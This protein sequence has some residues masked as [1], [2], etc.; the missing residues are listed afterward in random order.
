MS[1]INNMCLR[2]IYWIGWFPYHV[3]AWLWKEISC[4]PSTFYNDGSQPPKGTLSPSEGL[5]QTREWKT[6][7]LP[8][9]KVKAPDG[10]HSGRGVCV[11]TRT[12]MHRWVW[13]AEKAGTHLGR[14]RASLVKMK[15]MDL[16]GQWLASRTGSLTYLNASLLVCPHRVLGRTKYPNMHQ[17]LLPEPG[18]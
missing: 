1:I 4:G 15:N 9:R 5:Q 11:G 2:N 10:R 3:D 7:L 12:V 16:D 6:A 17:A 18:V 8:M 13:C 14:P